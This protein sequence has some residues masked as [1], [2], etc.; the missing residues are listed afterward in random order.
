M[1]NISEAKSE[2]RLL[3]R[4]ELI[5]RCRSKDLVDAAVRSG[6]LPV[7][8][9]GIEGSKRPRYLFRPEDVSRWLEQLSQ[10]QEAL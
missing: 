10:R 2:G 7:I 3:T 8:R 4:P 1:E 6:A 9:V 5:K